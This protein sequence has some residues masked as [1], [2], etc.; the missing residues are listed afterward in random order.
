MLTPT[1][2]RGRPSSSPRPDIPKTVIK[3]RK[4]DTKN[5]STEIIKD[6]IDHFAFID[7]FKNATL[8]KSVGCTMRT[9]F[10]CKKCNVHLCLTKERNCFYNFHC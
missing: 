2:K 8:C 7:N 3:N 9:H 4:I 10:F 6:K 1:R 5:P